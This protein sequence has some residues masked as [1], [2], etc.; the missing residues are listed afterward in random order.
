MPTDGQ[1]LWAGSMPDAY[2]RW[3]EPI[4]FHPFAVEL[5]ARAAAS[6]PARVLELAAGT[7]ALTK[8][9]LA[10]LP[11]ASVTAT[12]L[13][14]AMVQLGAE[15]A[16]GAA[17]RQADALDLP[18][19]DGEFDL[20]ACQFGVMFF[21][22]RIEGFREARRVLCPQGRLLFNTW[23]RVEANGFAHALVAVLERVFP[24]DPPTFVAAVPHGYAD[25]ELVEAEVSAAGLQV[26]SAETVVVEGSAD[27]AAALAAGFCT[28]TPLRA[29]IEARGDLTQLTKVI[30]GELEGRL[31][32]GP[33][34]APLAAY[35]LEATPTPQ[36]GASGTSGS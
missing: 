14:A 36:P 29:E 19:G 5:A 7:G 23:D 11:G 3:L 26:V 34:H 22:D 30:T 2:D 33:I 24:D 18:F 6:R 27:S 1:R 10:S 8:E 12:D 32:A 35:L 31:G 15:R 13:N 21:P 25:L 16:P 20:V 17:W 9:L 4:L 28:G